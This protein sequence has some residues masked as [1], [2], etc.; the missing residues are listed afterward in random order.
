MFIIFNVR[1]AARTIA[2][3]KA[4]CIRNTFAC[5]FTTFTWCRFSADFLGI[6]NSLT[7]PRL[8][9]DTCSR[10]R[11]FLSTSDKTFDNSPS[12]VI[13]STGQFLFRCYIFG[14]TVFI[15]D[16]FKNTYMPPLQCVFPHGQYFR[17]FRI[18]V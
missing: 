6:V 12:A 15:T 2:T 16:C 18:S 5:F 13:Q 17:N 1:I 11:I 7:M 3:L 14:I 9:V 8:I 4:K 10:H